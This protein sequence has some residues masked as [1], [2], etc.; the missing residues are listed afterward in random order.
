MVKRSLKLTILK[1]VSIMELA[2]WIVM[3]QF[4]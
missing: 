2:P 4:G 1:T 3:G